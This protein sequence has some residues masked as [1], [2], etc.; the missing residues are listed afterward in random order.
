MEKTS[1]APRRYYQRFDAFD[2]LLHGIL[3]FAFLGLAFTGLPLLFSDA[4]W[5]AYLSAVFGGPHAATIL[6]RVFA[7]LLIGCFVTHVMRLL[8]RLFVRK[9]L[10]ILWGP[11]SMTPQP[12]DVLEMLARTGFVSDGSLGKKFTYSQT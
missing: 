7:G 11:A 10:E 12:R 8:H 5:A 2:R 6:H 9:E 3:M 4:R 1:Q